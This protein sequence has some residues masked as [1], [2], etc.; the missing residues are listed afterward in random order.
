MEEEKDGRCQPPGQHP[1][2]IRWKHS[3]QQDA[4]RGALS[5]VPPGAAPLCS[6]SRSTP[7]QQQVAQA[8]G[9]GMLRQQQ[10]DPPPWS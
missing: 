4:A 3:M 9:L 5:G 6:P 8:A 1:A 10:R 2:R 7:T